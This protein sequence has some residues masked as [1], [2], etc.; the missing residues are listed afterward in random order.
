[1]TYYYFFINLTFII[2]GYILGLILFAIPIPD[3]VFLKSYSLSSK[4]LGASYILLSIINTT[5]LFLG[6]TD[7]SPEYL[8]FSGLLISSSQSL[9]FAF[10]L[11]TLLNPHKSKKI[12][13][14]FKIHAMTI[15]LFLT[16]YVLLS[17][18]QNDPVITTVP[19]L[20]ISISEPLTILRITFFV[21][22]IYQIVDYCVIFSNA[23]RKYT[24]S[25]DNFFSETGTIKLNGIKFSFFSALSIGLIAI[26]YQTLPSQLFDNFFTTVLVV[27]YT[28]F[29]I[30]FIN[31]NK[32]YH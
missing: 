30:N 32:I 8:R 19:D 24:N 26:I 10:I 15:L 25:I 31:Y 6:L 21:F 12:N 20:Y 23:V 14:T 4:I 28:V 3:I 22:Y 5:V 29:A 2:S 1:M 18:F 27:F 7:Y 16:G 13:I 11:V 9:L 17:L